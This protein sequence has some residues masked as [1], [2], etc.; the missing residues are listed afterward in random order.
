VSDIGQVFARFTDGFEFLVA[1]PEYRRKMREALVTRYFPQHAAALRCD[2]WGK[3]NIEHRTPNVQRRTAEN[4]EGKM[5]HSGCYFRLLCST[6]DV[7]R[8][9]LDVRRSHSFQGDSLDSLFLVYPEGAIGASAA[10]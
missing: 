10:G 3:A 7:G 8:S 2:S 9:M 4:Q 5:G 6:F 1:I